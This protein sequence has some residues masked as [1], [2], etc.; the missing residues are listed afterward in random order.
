MSLINGIATDDP[1]AVLSPTD[2][3]GSPVWQNVSVS[4]PAGTFPLNSKYYAT[5]STADLV[6]TMVGGTAVVPRDP[7]AIAKD[8]VNS[9]SA[10]ML[11][12]Q[13]ADG[14]LINA[15]LVADFFS[16]GYSLS[17][18]KTMIDNEVANVA[19]GN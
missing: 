11:M 14:S 9:A 15:G 8:D 13:M 18:V 10:P 3:F 17:M 2:V 7:F 1:N 16:H 19:K 6:K 12:V 5:Q 4:G